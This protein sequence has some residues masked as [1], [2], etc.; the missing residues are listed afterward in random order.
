MKKLIL[1]IMM[2]FSMIGCDRNK[3]MLI[4]YS[5]VWDYTIINETE[6]DMAY[7]YGAVET[8]IKSGAKEKIFQHDTEC[9]KN[10]KPTDLHAIGN[11][12]FNSAHKLMFD[13]ELMP[14]IIWKRDFW[15]FSTEVH[16]ASYTLTVTNELIE[17]LE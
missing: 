15:S 14:E 13:G 8:V 12:M 5:C 1:F 11:L 17:S 16:H 9:G 10:D 4:D 6:F 7:I 3:H 2:T